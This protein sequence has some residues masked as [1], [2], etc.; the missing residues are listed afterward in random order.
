MA[1]SASS[2]ARSK[3]FRLVSNQLF[4]M[5][6]L[7]STVHRRYYHHMGKKSFVLPYSRYCVRL[8]YVEELA[9]ARSVVRC[10]V[11]EAKTS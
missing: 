7:R 6:A 1:H 9:V 8:C 2:K 10:N 4:L 11:S 3:N 5:G